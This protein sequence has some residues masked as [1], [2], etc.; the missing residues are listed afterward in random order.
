MN[1]WEELKEICRNGGQNAYIFLTERGWETIADWQQ[2][3]ASHGETYT[4]AVAVANQR[5]M[6]C[7]VVDQMVARQPASAE[8]AQTPAAPTR[9]TKTWWGLRQCGH[10]A[11]HTLVSH[12]V[13]VY[14]SVGVLLP[15]GKVSPTA[16][17]VASAGSQH[18]R[19][20]IPAEYN[21]LSCE[22]PKV[23]Q[24]FYQMLAFCRFH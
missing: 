4:A 16:S 8:T 24:L 21:L 10:R 19:P 20:L 11:C 6:R 5:E 9:Q 1:P 14:V 22:L 15:A 12:R 17:P 23:P 18:K 3:P 7:P 13:C 2:G